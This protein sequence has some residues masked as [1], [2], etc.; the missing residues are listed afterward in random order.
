MP[1]VICGVHDVAKFAMTPLD[2]IISIHEAGFEPGTGFQPGPNI[3]QFRYPFTLHSFT[4]RDS[5]AETEPESPT[6]EII[7]RLLL[8]YSQTKPDSRMLFHC[9][10]GASRST[11]A[12]FLWLVH[13][14][15]SYTDAYNSIVQVRGPIV[16]P[17]QLMTRIA[18]KVMGK[19]GEL[20]AFVE[21]ENRNRVPIR[22]AFF[23][24]IQ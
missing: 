18:D 13:H 1:F 8:V 3:S 6:E 21:T 23:K 15:F 22:E 7:T 12:A 17:S 24:S 2:H 20:A 5:G 14:G 19:N 10:A 16:C 4:F 11:A 9:F